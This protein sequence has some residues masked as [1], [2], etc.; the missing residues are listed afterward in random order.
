MNIPKKG[1]TAQIYILA[2]EMELNE[3]LNIGSDTTN[4]AV[5]I[6]ANTESTLKRGTAFKGAFFGVAKGSTLTFGNKS[7]SSSYKNLTLDGNKANVTANAPL[8]VSEG[9]LV[10]NRDITLQN[11]KNYN[12]FYTYEGGGA[13][14]STGTF[15]MND[16]KICNDEVSGKSGYYPA[17]G[18]GVCAEGAAT[19]TGGEITNNTTEIENGEPYA[20]GDQLTYG[21]TNLKITGGTIKGSTDSDKYDIFITNADSVFCLSGNPVLGNVALD[22]ETGKTSTT[23]P[24]IMVDAA[25]SSN[26]TIVGSYSDFNADPMVKWTSEIPLGTQL[27]KFA[28]GLNA[29]DYVSKFKYAGNG[30][31]YFDVDS[32]GGLS[33][34]D[35]PAGH[36]ITITD[37]IYGCNISGRN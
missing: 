14:L 1:N 3:T 20:L 26:V 6:F 13:I 8:I 28:E 12:S 31:R 11:N 27:V 29:S 35:T 16:G 21:G 25:L 32:E 10:F 34:T 23:K 37:P 22:V 18:G 17:M 5:Q 19:I 15:M 33:L 24:Y 4:V 30:V 9:T 2:D 7:Q 36:G